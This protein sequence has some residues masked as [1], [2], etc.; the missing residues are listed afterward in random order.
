MQ[1]ILH[2]LTCA[3][4]CLRVLSQA[5]VKV[6][7]GMTDVYSLV[8]KEVLVCC[9]HP[10]THQYCLLQI[11]LVSTHNLKGVF[12][13]TDMRHVPTYAEVVALKTSLDKHQD[14]PVLTCDLAQPQA[15]KG[16][17]L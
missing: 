11:A 14:E 10:H 16:V 2:G 17:C 12:S 15:C 4:T 7:R 9:A 1:Y 6:R 3:S 8:Y 5:A 13:K